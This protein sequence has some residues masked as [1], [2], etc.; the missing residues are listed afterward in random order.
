MPVLSWF[1]SKTV[2]VHKLIIMSLAFKVAVGLEIQTALPHTS[3]FLWSN[4]RGVNFHF[5][6]KDKDKDPFI[7][8]QEFT[9]GYSMASEQP[10][11]STRPIRYSHSYDEHGVWTSHHTHCCILVLAALCTAPQETTFLGTNQTACIP[12]LKIEPKSPV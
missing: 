10:Q 4:T 1:P 5:N 11:S 2:Y 3:S 8:Q 7:G 9:V 12:H 6:D